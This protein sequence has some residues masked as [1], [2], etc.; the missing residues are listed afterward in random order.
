MKRYANIKQRMNQ[1]TFQYYAALHGFVNANQV[2]DTF[3]LNY[4][5]KLS[6]DL[7]VIVLA[8]E[9]YDGYLYQTPHIAYKWKN[10]YYTQFFVTSL[11]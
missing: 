5:Y 1:S 3:E 4:L 2:L 9:Q 7:P 10:R 11:V 6:K 8:D